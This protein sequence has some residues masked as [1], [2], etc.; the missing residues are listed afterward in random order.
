M[1][2]GMTRNLTG[3]ECRSAS[4]RA[5]QGPEQSYVRQP[6]A[7]KIYVGTF[8]VSLLQHEGH[9]CKLTQPMLNMFNIFLEENNDSKCKIISSLKL[10]NNSE[11]RYKKKKN[12]S[13]TQ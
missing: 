2:S 1:A 13:P 9:A 10:P 4:R 11:L 6:L 8:W 12:T 5:P 7:L 3:I